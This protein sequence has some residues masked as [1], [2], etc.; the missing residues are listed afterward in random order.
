MGTEVRKLPGGQD[1]TKER[2]SRAPRRSAQCSIGRLRGTGPS[3]VPGLVPSGL[4]CRDVGGWWVVSTCDS[5]RFDENS[6]LVPQ[7]SPTNSLVSK[8]QT[9]VI[10]FSNWAWLMCP[11]PFVSASSHFLFPFFLTAAGTP[12]SVSR[13]GGWWGGFG[14]VSGQGPHGSLARRCERSSGLTRTQKVIAFSLAL[15][16]PSH[17]RPAHHLYKF[18]FSQET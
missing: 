14:T 6:Q 10:Y 12:Y 8:A 4:P 17:H 15:P 18:C 3:F 11:S 5:P 9:L 2:Q 16:C 1:L 7:R 13:T